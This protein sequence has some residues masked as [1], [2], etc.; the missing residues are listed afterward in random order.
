MRSDLT[1]QSEVVVLAEFVSR[2]IGVSLSEP[3]IDKFA[4]NIIYL[5][6]T[7]CCKSLPALILSILCHSLFQT[8]S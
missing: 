4:V 2:L 1:G 6:R 3:H 5:C 7:S 8:M